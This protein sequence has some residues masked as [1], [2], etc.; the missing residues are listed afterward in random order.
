[1]SSLERRKALENCVKFMQDPLKQARHA[2]RTCDATLSKVT[3]EV[4]TAAATDTPRTKAF[5]T[6]LTTNRLLRAAHGEYRQV[7]SEMSKETFQ[8]FSAAA[9]SHPHESS[10]AIS[11]NPGESPPEIDDDGEAGNINDQRY[12]PGS[13]KISQV[14]KSLEHKR[15]HARLRKAKSRSKAKSAGRLIFSR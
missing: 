12:V 14:K 10:S 11:P 8:T 9:T 4:H 5:R 13:S 15:E 7:V 2:V 6:A 1:M 3:R